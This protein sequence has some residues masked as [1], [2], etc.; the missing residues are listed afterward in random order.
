M[1]AA[2]FA[3]VLASLVFNYFFTEP[4]HTLYVTR[5]ELPYYFIFMSFASLLAWFTAVRRRVE[6]DLVQS[7]DELK[8]EIAERTQRAGLLD[9]THDSI[10]V[11]DIGNVITFLNRGAEELYGWRAAEVVGKVTTSMPSCWAQ[12]AG[13]GELEQTKADGSGV[14]VAS[15]W[16]L[17]PSARL[18]DRAGERLYRR[19]P[20]AAGVRRRRQ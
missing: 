1:Q 10:C 19:D 13:K 9:L 18:A 12:V 5:S 7:R 3:L 4:L 20:D 2:V 17:Q 6:R 8:R 14:V 15:R 16:S 11:R